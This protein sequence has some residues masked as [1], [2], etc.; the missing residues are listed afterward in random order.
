MLFKYLLLNVQPHSTTLRL[1]IS[2]STHQPYSVKGMA[3]MPHRCWP[4]NWSDGRVNLN[5][6]FLSFRAFAFHLLTWYKNRILQLWEWIANRLD[7]RELDQRL[8]T[9]RCQLEQLTRM[10]AVHSRPSV[11]SSVLLTWKC[12]YL[13]TINTECICTSIVDSTNGKMIRIK[14]GLDLF[15]SEL[16]PWPGSSV[17]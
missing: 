4:S 10:C 5:E 14:D 6:G 1:Q 12:Q 17:G 8:W 3:P 7:I 16:G 2:S 13:E 15:K 9:R 11:D